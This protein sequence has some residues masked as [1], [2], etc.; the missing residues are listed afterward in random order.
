MKKKIGSFFHL[1]LQLNSE[2]PK[3]V[4]EINQNIEPSI[5][6]DKNKSEEQHSLLGTI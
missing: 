5:Q 1:E 4:Q 2:E 6:S 3:N